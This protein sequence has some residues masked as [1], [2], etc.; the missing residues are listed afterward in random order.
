MQLHTNHCLCAHPKLPVWRLLPCVLAWVPC[1]GL[2]ALSGTSTAGLPSLLWPGHM[3]FVA[4]IGLPNHAT[5]A[6][7]CQLYCAS[8]AAVLMFHHAPHGV[9]VHNT[10]FLHPCVCSSP[11]QGL[12]DVC[13]VR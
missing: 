9:P 13:M 5:S 3:D 11:L 10:L 12:T 2:G 6:E 7:F 8:L 1:P 4:W